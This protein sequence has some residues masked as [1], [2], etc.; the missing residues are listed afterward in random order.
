MGSGLLAK[1]LIHY[2]PIH[3]GWT[4]AG[5]ANAVCSTSGFFFPRIRGGYNLRRRVGQVP[6]DSAPIVGAAG[7]DATTIHTFGWIEHEASTAYVYRLTAVS[8]GGVENWT[9]EVAAA[10]EFDASGNWVGARPNSP[11]DLRVAPAEGGTFVLR[12]TYGR[13]GEQ[14]EPACFHVYHDGGTG[15]VDFETVVATVAYRRGRFHYCYHSE[16]FANGTRVR[17]VVRA[18]SAGQVEDAN[19]QAVS[20]WADAQAPPINPAVVISRA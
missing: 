5:I 18:V 3:R 4:R 19:A 15:T 20:G 1:W 7:A 2:D 6:D 10:A 9:D 14:A 8:G 16:G 13:Q 12:W 11:A 17:W